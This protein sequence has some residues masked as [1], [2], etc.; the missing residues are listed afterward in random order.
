MTI[1]IYPFLKVKGHSNR[2]ILMFLVYH[3]CRA[4]GKIEFT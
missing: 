1:F 3:K 2:H 4:F